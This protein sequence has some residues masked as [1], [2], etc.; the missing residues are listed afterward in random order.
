[1]ASLKSQAF[2]WRRRRTDGQSRYVDRRVWREEMGWIT[3]AEEMEKQLP[4]SRSRWRPCGQEKAIGKSAL[5]RGV[6]A[7]FLFLPRTPSRR[8][9]TGDPHKRQYRLL[10]LAWRKVLTWSR[11]VQS[12][13]DF[14]KVPAYLLAWCCGM[15]DTQVSASSYFAPRAEG[16]E[17]GQRDFPLSADKREPFFLLANAPAYSRFLGIITT[18]RSPS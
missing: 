15:W 9:G 16:K 6:Q 10:H 2:K 12:P 14:R 4:R 7:M 11:R 18:I 8:I 1:M 17:C 13:D 5:T 3:Q